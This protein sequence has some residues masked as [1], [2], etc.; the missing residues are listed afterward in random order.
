[1]NEVIDG[2][3]KAS[4]NRLEV[5]IPLEN[6][7]A[8]II[9]LNKRIKRCKEQRLQIVIGSILISCIAFFILIAPNLVDYRF[10]YYPFIATVA[11]F[12]IIS[13]GLF[14][15]F[16]TFIVF[17]SMIAS[18]EAS[19]EELKARQKIATLLDEEKPLSIYVDGGTVNLT[20]RSE[21][22]SSPSP[23]SSLYFK[24]LVSINLGNLAA[25]YEQVK[26]QTDK[27]FTASLIVGII[28]FIFIGIGLILGLINTANSQTLAYISSG[29]GIITEF[30]AAVFFY[31]YNRTV[32]QMKGYHDS[33]LDVQNILLSLK[34]VED[35]KEEGGKAKMVEKMLEYLV[36]KHNSA[37]RPRE[38]EK[39]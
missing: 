33:L 8:E 23:S 10:G 36:G 28:G 19:I 32:R 34:L 37:L 30:I 3:Y 5:D 21:D 38:S 11:F 35:T 29:S 2:L 12:V 18:L 7:E 17:Q 4:S 14:V 6:I 15:A 13:L 9:R 31:L 26:A 22:S 24:Q 27:S 20:S 1:M 25:Y 39:E 16:F